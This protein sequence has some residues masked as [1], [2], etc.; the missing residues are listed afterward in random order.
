VIA[1]TKPNPAPPA[2]ATNARL[3][4]AAAAMLRDEIACSGGAVS[5]SAQ[6][7]HTKSSPTGTQISRPPLASQQDS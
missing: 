6:T 2:N 4:A 7:G 1:R 5:G 3:A